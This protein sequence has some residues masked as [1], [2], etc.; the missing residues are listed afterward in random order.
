[1][2]SME[3]EHQKALFEWAR[4]A[5]AVHPELEWLHHVPNGGKR[6]R[7]TAARLKA[8]GVK[9][10]VPDIVLP[11]ARG[12]YFG[13]YIELKVDGG[14]TSANQDRWL[15]ALYDNG[16]MAVV[17]YGWTAARQVIE[18]YLKYKPTIGGKRG[19]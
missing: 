18:G 10:G 14:K 1:M 16:Y 9:A 6:D 2:Q 3:S 15:D 13:L 7:A 4:F 12:G 11:V 17:C 19:T 8:E 5:Q